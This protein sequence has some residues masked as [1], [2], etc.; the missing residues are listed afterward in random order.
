[1]KYDAAQARK[2]SVCLQRGNCRHQPPNGGAC[3]SRQV[4]RELKQLR[5]TLKTLEGE[6]ELNDSKAQQATALI[7]KAEHSM[8]KV[9]DEKVAERAKYQNELNIFASA[10]VQLEQQIV[11]QK[12]I[13]EVLQKRAADATRGAQQQQQQQQQH[14]SN[15]RVRELE[16]LMQD[17][18]RSESEHKIRFVTALN[19]K[20]QQ[21]VE[22]VSESDAWHAQTGERRHTMA[23]ST[24]TPV[25]SPSRA[26]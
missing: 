9:E 17:W 23:S 25:S 21:M 13:I 10:K 3:W 18:D 12:R 1:M 2:H 14:V 11:N 5:T 7:A 8:K 20:L 19:E 15:S 16:L 6:K 22:N 26:V 4:E 24:L